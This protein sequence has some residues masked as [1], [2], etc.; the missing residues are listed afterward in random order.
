MKKYI[1]MSVAAAGLAM[2]SCSDDFLEVTSP[3]DTF[4][5]EYYTTKTALNE[6]LVAAYAPLHWYDYG[7]TWNYCSLNFVAD[8]LGDDLYPN[9]GSSE[10]QPFLQMM[11]QYSCTPQV[12]PNGLWSDSYSGVKRC[13][14][15]LKYSQWVLDAGNITSS[16]KS[17]IDTQARLL[18]AFYYNVLWKFYGNIPC[19]MENLSAP[20]TYEQSQADE[21][22]NIIITELEDILATGSLKEDYSAEEKGHVTKPM[23]YMLYTEMVMLQNDKGRYDKALSYMKELIG[24]GKF[25]LLEDFSAIW[26]EENE[27]CKESIFEINYFDDNSV[28]GWGNQ[29][30]AGGSVAPRL[31]GPRGFQC[32][33]KDPMYADIDAGWG[34][35]SV[36]LHTVNSFDPADKRIKASFID[37]EAN[38][39]SDDKGWMYTGYHTYKYIC[40]KANNKDQKADADLG[41][42]NNLRVYRYAETLLNA[43]ELSLAAGNQSDAD[44]YLNEVRTRAGL[45]ATTATVESIIDERRHEFVAEGKRYFDLVRTGKAASTLTPGNDGGGHRTKAWTDAVRYLPIP[46]SDIDAANGTLKQ[47]GNY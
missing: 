32:N 1:L 45:P 12:A 5:E 22:Y 37:L 9:G 35:G 42:N 19:Y 11:F 15:V 10:D 3:T 41:F 16:E 13:N 30:G 34:F 29:L 47:N 25:A 46:Q 28:R 31:W 2:T 38:G 20:Y 26:D 43:A 17:D 33:S 6:A 4:I 24:S 44:K 39:S 18:R 7:S 21:V 23:A 8:L 27:W 14:D 36:P 40:K